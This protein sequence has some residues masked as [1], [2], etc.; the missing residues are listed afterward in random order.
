MPI[1][2][3]RVLIMPQYIWDI[4]TRT[5]MLR[6]SEPL[7]SW[8]GKLTLLALLMMLYVVALFIS[9]AIHEV[10]GH[11]LFAVLLGGNFYAV[12]L[13]PGSGYVSFWLPPAM[14][15]TSTRKK[16][17]PP[18]RRGLGR[19]YL[20]WCGTGRFSHTCAARPRF[21]WTDRQNW[22]SRSLARQTHP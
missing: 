18:P 2:K 3:A 16:K 14:S 12:Y 13:S 20:C 21:Y 4:M 19:W 7:T 22:F 9:I 15:N 1:K 8:E 11:G 6:M 5:G 10:L 17:P